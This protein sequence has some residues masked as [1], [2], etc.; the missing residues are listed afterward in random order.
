MDLYKKFNWTFFTSPQPDP[1]KVHSELFTFS[2]HEWRLLF[3]SNW[4]VL[5]SMLLVSYHGDLTE[6]NQD[7]SK[8]CHFKLE[9]IN[10]AGVTRTVENRYEF[11]ASLPGFF[12]P[13]CLDE[14]RGSISGAIISRRSFKLTAEIFI[15][16]TAKELDDAIMLTNPFNQPV[17]FRDFGKVSKGFIPYLEEVLDK[18]PLLGQPL[19]KR[20]SRISSCAFDILGAILHLIGTK[21]LRDMNDTT[22]QQLEQ[23]WNEV[24]IFGLDLS[25][26]G[27][28]VTWVLGTGD[29]IKRVQLVQEK[30][31]ALTTA[32]YDLECVTAVL[33][34]DSFTE[35]DTEVDSRGDGVL[36]NVIPHPIDDPDLN[37]ADFERKVG[38]LKKKVAEAQVE[39]ARIE[40]ENAEKRLQELENL[41]LDTELA[42][43]VV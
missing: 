36:D 31:N 22:Y 43:Q 5:Q 3:F 15:C 34:I 19:K 6:L 14:S 21:K 39:A 8:V 11:S 37:G 28:H 9:F 20:M 40:L 29:Y 38:S 35:S 25:W 4:G 18:Y 13:L 32:V 42:Y 24:G 12:F 27:S 17:T 1:N 16:E 23:L 33:L 2:D 10:Q 41:D 30:K 26:L 7:W